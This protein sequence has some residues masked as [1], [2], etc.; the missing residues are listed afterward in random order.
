[1]TAHAQRNVVPVSVEV[2]IE[3]LLP[4][5]QGDRDARDVKTNHEICRR[6]MVDHRA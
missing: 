1:M 5:A 2:R 4:I 6:S 3:S